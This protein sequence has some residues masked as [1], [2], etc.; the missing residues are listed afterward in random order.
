M[1]RDKQTGLLQKDHR[2]QGKRAPRRDR[3]GTGA[4]G[5][6][7]DAQGRYAQALQTHQKGTYGQ[8]HKNGQGRPLQP[9]E[10]IRAAG[11]KN[12]TVPHHHRFKARVL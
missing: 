10:D 11:Q 5:Q 3:T 7:T 1:P 6:G 4:Q 8:S 12:Q 9:A 2:Q